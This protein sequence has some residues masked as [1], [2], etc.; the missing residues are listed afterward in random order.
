MIAIESLPNEL[1]AAILLFLPPRFYFTRASLVCRRWRDT[2]QAALGSHARGRIPFTVNIRKRAN[3]SW[4]Y[5]PRLVVNSIRLYE[6]FEDVV[7]IDAE[8]IHT[9]RG[10]VAGQIEVEVSD[11]FFMAD[12]DLERDLAD[13]ISWEV[14]TSS[15]KGGIGVV[16]GVLDMA[17]SVGEQQGVPMG[18]LDKDSKPASNTS[19]LAVKESILRFCASSRAPEIYLDLG[20]LGAITKME[21]ANFPAVNTIHFHAGIFP[22]QVDEA[23]AICNALYSLFPALRRL[24]L[25][26]NSFITRLSAALTTLD[27]SENKV[28]QNVTKLELELQRAAGG[29]TEG[30]AC[31]LRLTKHFRNLRD[32]GT[33]Q[34]D[35]F[36]VF[37]TDVTFP[38]I[39]NLS[40]AMPGLVH[41]A[42]V[43]VGLEVPIRTLARSLS[44]IF[45]GLSRL[46]VLIHY[47]SAIALFSESNHI[48]LYGVVLHNG[49]FEAWRGFANN[50]PARIVNVALKVGGDGVE[51]WPDNVRRLVKE[52]EMGITESGKSGRVDLE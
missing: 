19:A 46:D 30:V 48:N 3:R 47:P 9:V 41:G 31:A 27:A 26:G 22:V 44:R 15:P 34:V 20:S 23:L 25:R 7:S 33:L 17:W 28:F 52:I 49:F 13:R 45:R 2:C 4:Y 16:V 5:V 14:G 36:T 8:G 43:R 35:G 42:N 37:P 6:V 38:N 51:D 50:V 1:L 18:F 39:R 40:I 12:M 24:H 11:S 21:E 29:Q 32:L 10:I